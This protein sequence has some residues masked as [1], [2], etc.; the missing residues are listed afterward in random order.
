MKRFLS[1]AKLL[2]VQQYRMKPFE[3]K[4]RKISTIVLLCIVA[5]CFLPL[6]IGVAIVT[7]YMGKLGGPD[8]GVCA[9]LVLMCQGL[10]VLFGLPSVMTNI[11]N[12]KDADKLLCLPVKANTIFLAKLLVVYVNEVITSV[13]SILII[14]LPYAIGAQASFGFYLMMPF[15][16]LLIPM[17]P[18]FVGCLVAMPFSALFSRLK[19]GSVWKTVIQVVF[20]L[21]VM[22]LY[23]W[24]MYQLGF[25]TDNGGDSYF[26]SQDLAQ[27]M[28]AQLKSVAKN[29]VYVHPDMMLATSMLSVTFGTGAITFFLSFLE[30]F[31]LFGLVVLV[32]YP[33]YKWILASSLES[34][35]GSSRR[36]KATDGQLQ[37][38]NRGVLKELIYTDFKRVVRNAQMGFQAFAGIIMMPL[39][40]VIMYFIMNRDLES[41]LTTIEALSSNASYHIIAPLAIVAY[42]SLIGLGTNSLG[43]YP[44]SRENKSLYLLKSLPISFSKILLA[45]VVLATGVMLVCDLLTCIMAVL[46]F[47]IEWYF[48]IIMMCAMALL[49]FGGMCVTTLLDLKAPRLGWTNFNQG[50]KNA[51]N[52][53][54]AMLIGLICAAVMAAVA[55]L[56]VI[57][58]VKTLSWVAIV[59]MWV[60]LLGLA[61][62][63]AAVAYHVMVTRAQQ[64]FE[65]IEP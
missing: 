30:N 24:V 7:Y 55:T 61:F 27:Q 9:M 52:S 25:M 64:C 41:G 46:L 43:L 32:A 1:L 56:F 57:W 58:F 26:P 17:L 65:K 31:A 13:F 35:G 38:K 59:L 49:G 39:L 45:K 42:M 4:R 60:M 44:I 5:L 34:A 16:V 10:V 40:V 47:R 23:I 2:F 28:I 8:E 21:L 14:L 18:L 29:M 62:A 36:K 50:L 20:Y 11:F 63:F 37:V 12:G 53:W 3:S 54:I 51:R 19:N 22:G 15:A 33:F 48:G 6:I